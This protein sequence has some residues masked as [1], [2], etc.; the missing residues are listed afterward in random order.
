MRNGLAAVFAAGMLALMFASVPVVAADETEPL[1]GGMSISIDLSLCPD[2]HWVGTITGDIE[3]TVEFWEIWEENYVVGATEHFFET[4]RITTD[5]GIISGVD[6]GVW[7]FAT[8]KFRALGWVTEASGD[9]AYLVGYKFHEM[10]ITSQFP[11]PEGT[12][13]VAGTG[14]LTLTQA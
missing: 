4:F 7:N 2:C 3:G 12:T 8:F 9:W 13:V 5:S 14:I 6:R 1:R 10:G 11:P